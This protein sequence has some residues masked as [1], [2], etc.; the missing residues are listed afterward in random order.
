MRNIICCPSCGGQMRIDPS[1]PSDVV[2]CPHC[3]V[4]VPV[5]K[6]LD[7]EG[8]PQADTK[9]PPPG[10]ALQPAPQPGDMYGPHPL[11][12]DKSS[13]Q[14]AMAAL[15]LGICSVAFAICCTLAGIILAIFGLVLGIQANK[16][17][18]DS[19]ATAGI[20]LS[21]I[22]LVLGVLNAA[23]GVFF[24]LAGQD[25]LSNAFGF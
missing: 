7:S 6:D 22:G 4:H 17:E 18:A 5:P 1:T 3:R 25:P 14:K 24:A 20:V 16:I 12:K 11:P 21:I 13:D 19:K 10:T 15:V 9:P 2:M 8:P 23:L